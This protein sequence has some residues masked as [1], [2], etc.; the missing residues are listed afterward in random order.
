[1]SMRINR[2]TN[3]IVVAPEDIG[4]TIKRVQS[5]VSQ[6]VPEGISLADELIADRRAAA[7]VE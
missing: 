1:M 6:Y 7:E 3:E 4:A 2:Q 5:L